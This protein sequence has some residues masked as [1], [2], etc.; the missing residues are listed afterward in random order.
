MPASWL[1]A[2]SVFDRQLR[3]HPR[4]NRRRSPLVS[5]IESVTGC[6]QTY[7]LFDSS[8]GR[9]PARARARIRM[10]T[11]RAIAHNEMAHAREQLDIALMRV[12]L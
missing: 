4:S 6:L 2:S 3:T 7:L 9:R 10:H 11:N 1:F 8:L 5:E 12:R